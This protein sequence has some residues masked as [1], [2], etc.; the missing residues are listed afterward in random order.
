[1]STGGFVAGKKSDFRKPFIL[2]RALQLGLA[3]Q[4]IATVAVAAVI[5]H[6]IV[7]SAKVV[8]PPGIFEVYDWLRVSVGVWPLV[9]FVIT[10]FWIYNVNRNTHV[11][12]EQK[13][14]FT[15]GWAVGWFFIPI[16]S[17]VQPYMVVSELY[18]ANK[19]PGD[20]KR[21]K[22][23]WITGMWWTT[24]LAGNILGLVMSRILEDQFGQSQEVSLVLSA[25]IVIHQLLGLVIFSRIGNWQLSANRSVT[26]E[27]VF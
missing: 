24:T 18:N 6:S 4:I 11:L 15:P 25:L 27:S 14:E 21:L 16:A 26:A 23:P 13:L 19:Q 8:L 10:L 1:M 5:A 12:S 2:T 22:R 20:W 3:V 17:L 9:N 7:T